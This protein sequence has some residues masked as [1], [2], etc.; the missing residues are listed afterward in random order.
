MAQPRAVVVTAR[1]VQRIGVPAAL[2]AGIALVLRTTEPHYPVAEW[3]F[4]HYALAWTL[5]VVFAASALSAGHLIVR[6]L[7]GRIPPGFPPGPPPTRKR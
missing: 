1:T 2:I 3:L 6:A 5:S 4:W 7:C